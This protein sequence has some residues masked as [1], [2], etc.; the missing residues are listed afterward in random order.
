MTINYPPLSE[1]EYLIKYLEITNMLLDPAQRL[2]Y[3][4]MELVAA[5]TILPD[6]KYKY[7]RFS[8]SAKKKVAEF[9]SITIANINNRIHA[10]TIKKFLRKDEDKVLYLPKHILK[11]FTEFQTNKKADIIFKFDAKQDNTVTTENS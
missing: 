1:Y 4:E 7:Q 2:T 11:A 9:L 10:L 3:G 6:E 5:I 8:M